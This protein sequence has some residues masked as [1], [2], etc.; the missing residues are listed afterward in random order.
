MHEALEKLHLQIYPKPGGYAGLIF[1]NVVQ[2]VT[3]PLPFRD[4]ER[5]VLSYTFKILIYCYMI[6]FI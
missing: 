5:I 1:K 2:L 3:F 4:N 6:I